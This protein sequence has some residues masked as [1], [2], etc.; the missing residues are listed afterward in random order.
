MRRIIITAVLLSFV[1]AFPQD[2]SLAGAT[3][4]FDEGVKAYQKGNLEEALAPFQESADMLEQLLQGVLSPE[5]EAYTK[6]FYATAQYYV[7]RIQKDGLMFESAS[8]TF[9]ETAGAFKAIETV[10]EEYVR[11]KYLRAMCSFR[12][13][14]LAVT[15]RNQMKMLDQAIGDFTDFLADED[16]QKNAKE[17][18]DYIDNANYY[19]GYC[20]YMLGYLKSFNPAQYSSAKKLYGEAFD[21]FSAAE[22]SSDERLS[23]AASYMGAA[24]HYLMARLY[25]R[26]NER[27]WG[28]TYKLSS[29][30]RNAAIEEELNSSVDVLNKMISAAGTQK[31]L[32]LMG[33][34]CKLIDMVSL[35][36]VGAKDQLN[37]AMGQMTDMRSNAKYGDE[38]LIRIA[39]ASLLNYLIF[40]G[41][42]KAVLNNMGRV[43]SKTPDALY[44][45]GWVQYIQGNYSDANSKFSSYTAKVESDRSSRAKELLAD[46]KFRQAECLFWLGVKQ[47]NTGLLTQA[48]NIYT[49]LANPQGKYYEHLTK[50]TRDIVSI[51]Q[52][53]IGIES[54][55]GKEKDVRVFDGAMAL[56]GLQLPRDAEKYLS[57]GKYFLQKGIETAAE[58]RQAAVRFATY[59]FDK[60]INAAVSADIKN[61]ARF[62]KGVALVKLAAAQEKSEATKTISD[63]EAVLNQ[64]TA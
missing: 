54:S 48:D 16:V 55:L 47:G 2:V 60:V 28:K 62:M 10:G 25:M 17:F 52:F 51:R 64:C 22:K 23:L 49:A 53:L 56:A 58:E 30:E 5:D 26:V 21:A 13:Y 31:D 29:K 34:V 14:Q 59:A 1:C 50:D 44:W 46:A 61:R 18:P 45:A 36:S 38:M 37:D 6:Y 35:G 11:A 32:Q 7:A 43:A 24:T 33:K 8:Q 12:L 57:V 9:N 40:N 20:K 41:P 27:D 15:E 39:D 4:K 3:S 42:Q 19:L 63:A